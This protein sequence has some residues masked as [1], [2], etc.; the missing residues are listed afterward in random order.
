VNG[1]NVVNGIDLSSLLA[2]WGNNV[3]A[4][5]FNSDGTVNGIDLTTLLANWD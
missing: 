1:D 3:P 2:A 4:A 5:D